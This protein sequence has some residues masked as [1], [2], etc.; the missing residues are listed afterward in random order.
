MTPPAAA[1]GTH[2]LTPEFVALL[3]HRD[4]A[5]ATVAATADTPHPHPDPLRAEPPGRLRVSRAVALR[6]IAA[7]I[8]AASGASFAESY[9]GLWKWALRHQLSG[10]WAAAFP[11][12]IDVFIAVG[13]LALFVALT[14]RWPKRSRIGAWLVTLAGLAVSVAGNVGHV[15]GHDLAS[16]V[17]AAVPPVAAAA[18]L[19]VGLG[20]LKRVVE[21]DS[22]ATDTRA[23]GD[24]AS[25]TD[26]DSDED[27]SDSDGDKGGDNGERPKRQRGGNG[28][29]KVRDILKRRPKLRA[30]LL[31]DDAKKRAVAKTATAE[32]AGVS[33]RTVERVLR[34]IAK[35]GSSS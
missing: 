7:L 15:S 22:A 17:T 24:S 13:E 31:G 10:F 30:D 3:R 8:T 23:S 18:A 4:H 25:D 12:Q 26:N 5:D 34:E 28:G 6:A 14:D 35:E 33:E 20:V 21:R 1:N 16:R 2:V 11:A 27:P 19:A 29:D 9:R 32:A